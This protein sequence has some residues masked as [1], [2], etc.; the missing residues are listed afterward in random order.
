MTTWKDALLHK[1][2][3]AGNLHYE[4]DVRAARASRRWWQPQMTFPESLQNT[5]ML[6]IMSMCRVYSAASA[7]SLKNDVR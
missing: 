5:A 3:N 7:P 1:V 2:F 6:D 4:M